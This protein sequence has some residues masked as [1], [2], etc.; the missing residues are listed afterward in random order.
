MSCADGMMLWTGDYLADTQHLST[1]Q[2]G[3]YLL[4][5]MAIWRNGGSLP[6]DE[7]R[8][9]SCAKLTMSQWHRISREIMELLTVEDGVITQKRLLQEYRKTTSK[10]AAKVAAGHASAEAK[11]LKRQEAGPTPVDDLFQQD[12]DS[13]AETKT[14][15]QNRKEESD[16][17]AGATRPIVNDPFDEFWAAYPRRSGSNPRKPAQAKFERLVRDGAD[18][19]EIIN[20]AKRYTVS[21]ANENKINTVYV[22]QALTW[23]NQERWRD[24]L[25]K[26]AKTQADSPFDGKVFAPIDSKQWHEWNRYK[27]QTGDHRGAMQAPNLPGSNGK[28]GWYFDEEWPPDYEPQGP[29]KKPEQS[30]QSTQ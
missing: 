16:S 23:L 11:Y 4:I 15:T 7:R 6:A 14:Q 5:L 24:D 29:P 30:N 22:A 21:L 9:A 10:I 27:K 3:A 2:H 20:G 25:P 18:P 12:G 28:R 13:V 1:T 26:V 17:V 19:R 8:L